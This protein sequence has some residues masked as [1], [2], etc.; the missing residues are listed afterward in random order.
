MSR[1]RNDLSH[2]EKLAIIDAYDALPKMSQR[3]AATKLKIPQ[4]TL[5]KLLSNRKVI[6]ESPKPVSRKRAREGKAPNVERATI[7]WIASMRDQNIPLTGPLVRQKAE[8]FATK[9]NQPDFKATKGWYQRFKSRNMLK[10]IKL[11]GE[12]PASDVEQPVSTR[13]PK[14]EAP[15][16]VPADNWK[17]WVT[18]HDHFLM[19][20]SLAPATEV[21][22]EGDIDDKILATKNSNE[23]GDE[24]E[25]DEENEDDTPSVAQMRQAM[26]VI[27]RGLLDRNIDALE[28][29]NTLERQFD[30]LFGPK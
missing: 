8:D 11:R 14:K 29:L 7:Q 19:V 25:S 18:I 20:S 23:E 27:R 16:Q 4:S 1:P 2:E 17:S 3:E 28:A 15:A 30:E 5:N 21:S 6:L 13:S 22:T 9:L 10:N 26:S 24:Q 12:G